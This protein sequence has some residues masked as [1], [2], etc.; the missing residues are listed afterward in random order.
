[1]S[2][3]LFPDERQVSPYVEAVNDA[4]FVKT[5]GII[6]LI[7]S[8]ITC[9]PGV[10]IGVGVAVL[11]F[12]STK[13]FRIL[14][15]TVAILGGLSFLF[16]P[17]A[18]LAALVLGIGIIMK[19]REILNVLEKEGRDDSDWEATRKRVNVGLITSAISCLIGLLWLSL[20]VLMLLKPEL[21]A[22]QLG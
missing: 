12:G 19:G 8:L 7:G 21:F 2:Y 4:R 6:A 16:R 9:G 10:M 1:M 11:G 22:R 14:G 15:T 17:A 20:F 18:A 13:Y 3:Q 5:F